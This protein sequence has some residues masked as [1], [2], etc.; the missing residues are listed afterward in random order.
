VTPEPL[1]SEPRPSE[2]VELAPTESA[3]QT[4]ALSALSRPRQALLRHLKVAG[5]ATADQL[6]E[7][8]SL[9]VGA[10]R[11]LIAPLA[12]DGLIAHRDERSR[13]GRPRR[14]YC[15]T[16]AAEALFPKRYGQLAN[17]L[18][19]LIEPD[20]V[21]QAF[22]ERARQRQ[23]RAE[24][25]LQGLAFD[26]KVRELAHILD[27]D[28]YLAECEKVGPNWWRIAELNCAILDVARQYRTACG[29]ELAFIRAV[30]P[31]ADVER[32]SHILSGGHACSYEI[33]VRAPARTDR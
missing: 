8:L 10:V 9:S 18:L 13:P 17:Q 3:G 30:L 26:A 15:L 33:R 6:A 23:K 25:R 22:D 24:A 5:Q 28:G 32:V 31:E 14:W 2:P 7:E 21:D 4:V 11:Q 1:P 16:P 27:E 29:T 12:G 19:G 20:L